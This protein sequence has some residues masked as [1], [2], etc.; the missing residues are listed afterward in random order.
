MIEITKRHNNSRSEILP[1]DRTQFK[2]QEDADTDMFVNIDTNLICLSQSLLPV[3][4]FG[5]AYIGTG[6]DLA[7]KKYHTTF[8]S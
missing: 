4:V 6:V 1:Q 2:Y 5:I 8:A 7:G 3:Q